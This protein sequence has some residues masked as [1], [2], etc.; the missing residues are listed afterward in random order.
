MTGLHVKLYLR[1]LQKI[2]KQLRHKE[3][4]SAPGPSTGPPV[5]HPPIAI[6][7]RG[8]VPE[9]TRRL[10]ESVPAKPKEHD[11]TITGAITRDGTG[12]VGL[13]TK[14]DLTKGVGASTACNDPSETKSHFG[15]IVFLAGGSIIFGPPMQPAMA[16]IETETKCVA[17]TIPSFSSRLPEDLFV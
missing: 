13:H 3:T 15:W 9:V 1:T 11:K 10:M 4:K 2:L 6:S 17:F 12:H 5:D 14:L 16:L 7:F 8:R